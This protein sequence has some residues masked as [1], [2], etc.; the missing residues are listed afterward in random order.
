MSITNFAQRASPHDV[1]AAASKP[2]ACPSSRVVLAGFHL[3]QFRKID[4]LFRMTHSRF[5][6]ILSP[7]TR[8][9]VNSSEKSFGLG[10][11]KAR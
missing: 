11:C 8:L 5:V 10:I 4:H 7:S 1:I 3:V 6:I 2:Q 9:R